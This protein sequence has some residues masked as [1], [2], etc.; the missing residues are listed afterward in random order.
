MCTRSAPWMSFDFSNGFHCLAVSMKP[1]LSPQFS[2]GS[3]PVLQARDFAISSGGR[4]SGR[5]KLFAATPTMALPTKRNGARIPTESAKK[6]PMAGPTIAPAEK[7][8]TM[9]EMVLARFLGVLM[10][11]RYACPAAIWKEPPAPVMK[12][13][14]TSSERLLAMLVPIMP[15]ALRRGP[16]ERSGRLPTLS[17]AI[18]AGMLKRRRVMPITETSI[19]YS[20][21]LIPSS[22]ANMGITGI[23]TPIAVPIRNEEAAILYT[24]L[25]ILSGSPSPAFCTPPGP[26]CAGDPTPFMLFSPSTLSFPFSLFSSA[27]AA[28]DPGQAPATALLSHLTPASRS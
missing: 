10:S 6:P 27:V 3:S 13:V 25:S 20:T 22:L 9:G 18:A 17:A 8:A 12:R 19:P 16:P 7:A 23:T 5:K 28:V 24:L 2:A 4:V 21:V 15:T 1:A 14:P 11:E 26:L